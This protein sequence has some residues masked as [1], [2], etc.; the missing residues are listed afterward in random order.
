MTSQT[1]A[2]R[3]D[4]RPSP[5]P[6]IIPMH[7][8]HTDEVRDLWRRR[9]GADEQ[10]MEQWVADGCIEVEEPTQGFVAVDRTKVVAFGIATVAGAE[11]V[12]E[13]LS[14]DVDVD[15]WEPTGVLHILVTHEDYE[16]RG[17]GSELVTTRLKWIQSTGADGVI[18]VSWHREDHRDSRPLFEKFGFE[19]VATIE[20]YY[21][22]LEGYVECVDCEESCTCDATIYRRP[23]GNTVGDE[24]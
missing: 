5:E 9:F 8:S 12:R 24:Q 16:G 17:L 7:E 2:I 1:D 3:D 20:E 4:L 14:V 15:P 10:I 11:Y 6:S 18:G 23:L 21:T 19:A 22:H 13:Y